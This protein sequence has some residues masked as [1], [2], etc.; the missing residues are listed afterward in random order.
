MSAAWSKGVSQVYQY[1]V[2]NNMFPATEFTSELELLSA[3]LLDG[4]V[5]KHRVFPS[6]FLILGSAS[7]FLALL[8]SSNELSHN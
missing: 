2:R 7:F 8:A 3:L 5:E 1:T 4:V 6:L